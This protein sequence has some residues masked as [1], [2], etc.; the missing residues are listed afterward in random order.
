MIKRKIDLDSFCYK[1]KQKVMR[2][3]CL[4]MASDGSLSV[5]EK[6]TIVEILLRDVARIKED[7]IRESLDI[8][9]T[10][11]NPETPDFFP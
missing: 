5:D 9:I 6:Q 11:Q 7:V 8:L 1:I 3:C 2:L 10:P 4:G